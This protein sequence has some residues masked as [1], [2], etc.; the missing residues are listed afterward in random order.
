VTQ[1]EGRYFEDLPVGTVIRTSA[2]TIGE[3]AVDAFAGLTGDYSYVHTD[4]E[5][6]KETMYGERIVH[7]LF[8]LSVLQ[9]LIV[10]TRYTIDTGLATL[11]W[12]RIRFPIAVRLG[13][14]V[15]GELTIRE[16]RVSRSQPGAGIVTEDC[17]LINQ[18]GEAVVTGDH[19][20]MVMR[21]E[22]A[23]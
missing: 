22:G 13:D 10:Q 16:A 14:T 19:V 11:G 23:A 7:G 6:V 5:A 17:R 21:R 15:R 12:E 8:S 2:R 20:L 1:R 18:R 3:G 4:A 9:G